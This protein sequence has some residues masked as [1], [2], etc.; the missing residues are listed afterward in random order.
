MTISLLIKINIL[1][2]NYYYYVTA[3]LRMKVEKYVEGCCGEK[4]FYGFRFLSR[5]FNV[6]IKMDK[7]WMERFFASGEVQT[8]WREFFIHRANSQQNG[9]NLQRVERILHR[10]ARIYSASLDSPAKWREFA[11]YRVNSSLNGANF[12]KLPIF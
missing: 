5:N 10:M 8:K 6:D 11:A 2:K 4:V 7:K 3:I 9:V 12:P 1:R